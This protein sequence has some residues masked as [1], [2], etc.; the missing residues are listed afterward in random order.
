MLK[1]TLL[2]TTLEHV[3]KSNY[4]CFILLLRLMTSLKSVLTVG[5]QLFIGN[6]SY[7]A[8]AT[9]AITAIRKVENA[10]N[11]DKENKNYHIT[12]WMLIVNE[13]GN[14]NNSKYQLPCGCYKCYDCYKKSRKYTTSTHKHK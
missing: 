13:H 4:K 2:N 11:M 1:K 14:Y 9:S 3:T 8:V 12:C 10:Q 5:A 6:T 7:R